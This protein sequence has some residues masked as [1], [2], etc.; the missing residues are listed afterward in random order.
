ML[1]GHEEPNLDPARM[2]YDLVLGLQQENSELRE[3]ARRV[4]EKVA[5]LEGQA[6]GARRQS[7]SVRQNWGLKLIA[8]GIAIA[9]IFEALNLTRSLLGVQAWRWT[10]CHFPEVINGVSSAPSR[11]F[12]PFLAG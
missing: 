4:I 6:E 5:T 11:A 1:E 9:I 10:P 8:I 2:L 7:S 3:S 12:M